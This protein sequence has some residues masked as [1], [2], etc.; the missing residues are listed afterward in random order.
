VFFKTNNSLHVDEWHLQS[1]RRESE[2][3]LFTTS[4]LCLQ[5]Q[6]AISKIPIFNELIELLACV[7][8]WGYK[9]IS[10][11]FNPYPANVENTVSS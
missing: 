11:L 3:L 6:D 1:F 5:R 10:N 9:K 8:V 7:K 2:I 4:S